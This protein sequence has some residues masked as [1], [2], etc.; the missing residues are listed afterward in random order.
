MKRK[1]IRLALFLAMM[2]AL[3]SAQQKSAAD[4]LYD[5]IYQEEVTGNL[6][7]AVTLLDQVLRDCSGKRVECA[8]ALYHLG[9]I[10]E[11]R[12]DKKARDY[13]I[14]L[15]ENY[16]E[17]GDYASLAR[18]RI[19]RLSQA[20]TFT[21]PRDGHKYKWVKIG[22]QTWM[23]ENLAYMPHVNPREKQEYGI[24]VYD[25]DDYDIAGAKA[26]ENYQ[27]YGCLYDWPTAMGLDPGYLL[28]EWKSTGKNHQGICPPGWFIPSD[29]DWKSLEAAIGMKE[30]EL[31]AEFPIRGGKYV[32]QGKSH[33]NP[34]FASML[35]SATDWASDGDGV[36]KYGFGVLPAG[37]RMFPSGSKY[38]EFSDI[39]K[40]AYLWTS[41]ESHTVSRGGGQIY[42]N[43]WFRTFGPGPD[44][45][46]DELDYL[47]N[48]MSVRCVKSID[49]VNYEPAQRLPDPE[50]VLVQNSAKTATEAWKFV[51][52]PVL[53]ADSAV[54][55]SWALAY[56]YQLSTPLLD[57][58]CLYFKTGGGM[59]Y[60]LNKISGNVEWKLSDQ[61]GNRT[62]FLSGNFII[63]IKE[64]QKNNTVVQVL[65]KSTG[66]LVR[67][68]EPGIG[69]FS[70][71]ACSGS[72]VFIQT[73]N[74][75]YSYDLKA[76]TLNWR[77]DAPREYFA[78]QPPV[79]SDD[80][81]YTAY[82]VKR[83][84][85]GFDYNILLVSAENGKI[86]E[87]FPIQPGCLG[88]LVLT[89]D[90]ILTGSADQYCY[91]YDRKTGATLWRSFT[92]LFGKAPGT[93]DG[94]LQL[95]YNDKV[96]V[97]GT[98]GFF[99]CLDAGTG[100]TKWQS[101]AAGAFENRSIAVEN[102]VITGNKQGAVYSWDTGT[103]SVL[104]NFNTGS[105]IS[106][107]PV[108]DGKLVFIGTDDGIL[109]AIRIPSVQ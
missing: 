74:Q 78:F 31:S 60:C 10:A 9:L 105:Q 96:Y 24:W 104:W 25:Y 100:N 16:P 64:D 90:M 35:K 106:S 89:R 29:E 101:K 50:V 82:R 87:E 58:R 68:I 3:L 17:A 41:T 5:A 51:I 42:L 77:I 61:G 86:L 40:Y 13:Y 71:M 48:G 102:Q 18:E 65:D 38:A 37:T 54:I 36:D 76:G 55:S 85:G 28:K 33:D 63:T 67:S 66:K 84:S 34:P 70:R 22:N 59:L 81:V 83:P 46:R 19:G 27:K 7:K 88:G 45:R 99:Y 53:E 92:D 23:A 12:Q 8:Q 79:L 52:D 20:N 80:L 75:L 91:A 95:L 32:I 107:S 69:F 26:T 47:R 4:L 98:R 49:S 109:H 43:A 21:D 11:R 57:D 2:P 94:P 6:D 72:A 108:S 1:F 97:G 14:R 15:I 39:N 103:G 93:L 30:P 56:K 62:L 73:M 44:I